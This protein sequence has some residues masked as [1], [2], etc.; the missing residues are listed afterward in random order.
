MSFVY[1]RLLVSLSHSKG[2]FNV[3]YQRND[4]SISLLESFWIL[5]E[6]HKRFVSP[7]ASKGH[8]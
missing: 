3:K 2:S 5:F 8:P 7:L 4:S 6:V 1:L